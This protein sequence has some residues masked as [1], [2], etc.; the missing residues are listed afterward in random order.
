MWKSTCCSFSGILYPDESSPL[1]LISLETNSS[2]ILRANCARK[3][4][5]E[6]IQPTPCLRGRVSPA[7][8]FCLPLL[9]VVLGKPGDKSLGALLSV[10]ENGPKTEG[11]PC[12]FWGKSWQR[13][14]QAEAEP[15]S[16]YAWAQLPVRCHLCYWD[17]LFNWL[18]EG[19]VMTTTDSST[20]CFS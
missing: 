8:L 11:K 3:D 6:G 12:A 20:L 17:F 14:L 2:Q 7:K 4:L 5:G 9:Q 16:L 13:Q 15:A 19:T 18:F 10:S 1:P